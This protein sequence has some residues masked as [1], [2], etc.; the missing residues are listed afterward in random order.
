MDI[1]FT[2]CLTTFKYIF[3]KVTKNRLEFN[4]N[5]HIC[6]SFKSKLYKK[7]DLI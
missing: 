1:S 7:I 2:N 6:K 5:L 4:K 3:V